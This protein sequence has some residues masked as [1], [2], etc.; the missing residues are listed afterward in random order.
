M[1]PAEA[2]NEKGDVATSSPGPTPRA[3]SATSRASVPEET[4]IACFTES[5]SASAFSKA[6]CAGPITKR[7]EAKTPST[8]C[9]ISC[10]SAAS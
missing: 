9:A 6:S 4:P 8:A 7:P 1:T 5:L 3:I 2:K 10:R